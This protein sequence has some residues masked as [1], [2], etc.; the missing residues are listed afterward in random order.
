MITIFTNP[1]P[2]KGPFDMIQR[3]AIESWLNLKEKCQIILFNSED[4]TALNIAHD[5][6]IQCVTDVTCNE[7]G[8]PLLHSVFEK[9][10]ALSDYD[11]IAQVNAD[12]ILFDDFLEAI[13]SIQ[14]SVN[15]SFLMIGRR[16]DLDV[17]CRIDYSVD[18]WRETLL[19]NVKAKGKLHGLSGIDYCVFPKKLCFEPPPFV[20]GKPGIDGWFVY[21]ARR[22]QVP[23]IDT[24]DK[25]TIVH[26]NH[27]YPMK[28]CAQYEIERERNT[29]LAGGPS[30]VMSLRDA[31]WMLTDEGVIRPRFK[32]RVLSAL[33]LFY[34]WRKLLGY[35]RAL[36]I[37]RA[38]SGI[39]SRIFSP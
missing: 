10:I 19:R 17:N 28:E 23:V 13:K 29:K 5:Y 9:V 6:N 27:N 26:Q 14:E 36:Q 16:W 35:K 37:I 33:S 31:N 32:R 21:K 7:Y 30:C 25:V 20:I 38:H 39:I 8:T 22:M 12:I 1:R 4:G 15:S 2:F 24:T 34:P 11:I 3:N 18:D